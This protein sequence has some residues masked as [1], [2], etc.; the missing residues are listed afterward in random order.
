MGGACRRVGILICMLAACRGDPAPRRTSGSEGGEKTREGTSQREVTLDIALEEPRL[1]VGDSARPLYSV[2]YA[3]ISQVGNLLVANGRHEIIQFDAAGSWMATFGRSG[4][5]P[6][7]FQALWD[8]FPRDDGSILA[9]DPSASRITRFQ[10]DADPEIALLPVSF[11]LPSGPSVLDSDEIVG[12]LAELTQSTLPPG[13]QARGSA[14]LVWSDA[15]WRAFDTVM[16]L[17]GRMY[18]SNSRGLTVSARS[19]DV[20]SVASANRVY[21]ASTDVPD[22]QVLDSARHPSLVLVLHLPTAEVEARREADGGIQGSL[23]DKLA[24]T[25][26]NTLWVRLPGPQD[27]AVW[28]WQLFDASGNAEARV[29]TPRQLRITQV[30]E[31][32]VLGVWTDDLGVQTVRSFRLGKRV[33]DSIPQMGG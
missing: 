13:A 33:T 17:P 20:L 23:F 22:I 15:N 24:V 6:G 18:T 26:G 12:I 28:E 27:A 10:P 19:P 29:R 31:D 5:G 14:H 3:K 1:V 8:I 16:T 25:R 9:Y 7:E 30:S 11:A 2:T 4:D 32:R 21:V